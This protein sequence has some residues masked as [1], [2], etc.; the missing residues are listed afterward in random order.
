MLS[1]DLYNGLT[2]DYIRIKQDKFRPNQLK[3]QKGRTALGIF[4]EQFQDFII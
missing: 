2:S 3:E 4:L 1:T